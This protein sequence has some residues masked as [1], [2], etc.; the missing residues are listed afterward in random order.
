MTRDDVIRSTAEHIIKVGLNL[1]AVVHRLSCRA[2]SHDHSKWSEEEWPSFERATPRLAEVEYG[3]EEYKQC[4]RDIRPAVDLHQQR[5]R[6]HPEYY[7]EGIYGM[8]LLDLI[9]MLADWKAASERNK[10]GNLRASLE[11][12][13]KRFRIDKQLYAVLCNTAHELG[14]FEDAERE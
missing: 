7:G 13:G 12:N 6:H 10:N 1:A 9:E 14:W 8:S 5:N 11:H 3:T 2:V 4:L